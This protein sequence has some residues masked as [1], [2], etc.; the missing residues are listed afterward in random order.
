MMWWDWSEI[1]LLDS[2]VFSLLSVLILYFVGSGILKLICTLS[3]KVDP[4]SSFDFVEKTNFRIVFGF[5]FIFLFLL[6]FSFLNL[7][8]LVSTLLV[9]AIAIVGFVASRHSF[10]L[11]FP[12]KIHLRNYV[13]I[14]AVIVIILT[15]MF[16]SS[17]L[18]AGFYGSTN[19]DGAD[20]TLM[21]RIILDNPNS[22]ITRVAQ[23]YAAFVLNYP[24][25]THVFSAFLLTLLNVPIQKI[26]ILVSA[27]L[28]GLIA[29]SFYSTL[30]CLFKNKALSVLGL[31]ITAFFTIGLSWAPVYWGGLP[32]LL[33][34]YLT[35]SSMGLIYVFLLEDKIS[36][37]NASL[38]GLAFFISFQ[39]YPIGV[40][41][42]SFWFLLI[43]IVKLLPKYRYTRSWAFS[44]SS[45]VNRRNVGLVMGFLVPILLS[46]PY[47]LS[48]YVND[49]AGAR[50]PIV[51]SLNS[52]SS[53]TSEIVKTK[54]SFNW[55]FDIPA[56]SVFFSEFGKLLS[57]ASI[58]LILLVILFIS[59]RSRRITS[60]FPLKK[61]VKGLLLVYLF[62][63]IIMI[64]LALTL[65]SPIII[66]SNLFDPE[67][68]WQHIFIPATMMAAVVIFS[69]IYFGY[70]ASKQLFYH[71]RKIM[72]KITKNRILACVILAFMVLIAGFVCIPAIAE[73]QDI[74]KIV[75]LSFSSYETLKQDDLLL[76]N[77]ITENVPSQEHI[78]VSA[79]DSGQFVTP[80]TQRYTISHYS[81]LANYTDL[82]VLLTSNSSDLKAVPLLMEYNVSYIYVGST[83]TVYAL[84]NPYYRHF[85]STQLFAAPYFMLAKEVGGAWLFQ[86]NQTAALSSDSY[87]I[88]KS[89]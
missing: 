50:F 30:N 63:M 71:P 11:S 10:K 86:F 69:A 28:P 36:W 60:V 54:I 5:I 53:V 18:I 31:I 46:V 3:K 15:V 42:L 22:L 45:I 23:P 35:I 24:S 56:L 1:T 49:I 77:W 38:M 65:F 76:M 66:L 51:N 79:G 48:Y 75:G 4:F 74:Y 89:D 39:T 6:I 82:M 81:Y 57:I 34:Y 2:L 43:L 85:N 7:T 88:E 9:V 13:P 67:R 44:I 37:L 33:S 12:K 68:V 78:L 84:Q 58:S 8:F 27:I 41:I 32:L 80:I 72:A 14:I 64:Y 19:D 62:M 20:H 70:L 25:G 29:L 61:F 83:A 59:T 21:V 52:V 87:G 26:I 16:F 40:L 55:V 47:I 17:M 73:Q